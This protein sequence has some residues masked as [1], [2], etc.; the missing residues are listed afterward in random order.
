MLAN[1]EI[2]CMEAVGLA[3]R[4]REKELSSVEVVE[5]VLDRMYRLEPMV[6]RLLH[7]DARAGPRVDDSPG[8]EDLR[9]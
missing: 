6:A 2:C 8:A 9:G 5:V 3:W 1:N 7:T 4:I